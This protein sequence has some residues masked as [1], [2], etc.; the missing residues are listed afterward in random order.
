MAR[1]ANRGCFCPLLRARHTCAGMH[2]WR[3]RS[4]FADHGFASHPGNHGGQGEIRPKASQWPP[5]CSREDGERS[6]GEKIADQH[7]VYRLHL[8]PVQRHRPTCRSGGCFTAAQQSGRRQGRAGP[9]SF[10]QTS[11]FHCSVIFAVRA[12]YRMMLWRQRE[13]QACTSWGWGRTQRA[14][15]SDDE[16]VRAHGKSSLDRLL[17]QRLNALAATTLDLIKQ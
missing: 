4:I 14:S 3:P 1:V 6:P 12:P 15:I 7:R 17:G 16:R 13:R 5:R 10:C 11:N 9:I 8:C 2:V